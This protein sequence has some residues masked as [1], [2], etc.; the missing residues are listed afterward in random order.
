M[1]YRA[2]IQPNLLLLQVIL[3]A[4]VLMSEWEN[5]WIRIFTIAVLLF[6][7]C[8]FFI[9]YSFKM[10][11]DHLTYT[12]TLLNISIYQKKTVQSNIKKMIFKRVG[13]KT[14]LAVIKLEKGLSIRV[15]LFTP[16]TIYEDLLG[17]CK[18]NGIQ[19]EKT[20]DYLILEKST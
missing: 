12:V 5:V 20:K 3:I 19:V 13:W 11:E 4:T 9:K 14:K 10:E 15:S 16:N 8:L 6:S 1:R 7:T 18:E 2:K 17:F